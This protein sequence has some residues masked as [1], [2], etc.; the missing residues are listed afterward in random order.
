MFFVLTAPLY[1]Q[2]MEGIEVLEV[3][4]SKKS[5]L[6]NRGFAEG[7]KNGD[8][9]KL[10]LKDLREGVD[11][12]RFVY[13]GEGECINVKNK[14]SYWFLRKIKNF[15]FIKKTQRLVMVRMAKDPR[16]PFVTKRTLRVQG[17]LEDQD[18]Y[19]VSEDSGVPEDLIFEEDDFFKG[20]EVKG[21]TPKKRQD[22][23][24]YRKSPYVS[25]GEEYDE[26]FD[27]VSKNLAA[28]YD[29]GDERL[30]EAI[31][32]EAKN[33][34][35][36]STTKTSV[37]K[38]NDLKYGL[39]GLYKENFTDGSNTRNTMDGLNAYE[40]KI[41]KD[42]LN[43]RVSPSAIARIKREGPMWSK[44]MTDSQLRAYLIDTG[45]EEELQRQ[46]RALKEKEGHEFTLRYTNNLNRNTTSE[47]PNFQ[48][49][50]YAISLSY[51]W[52]LQGTSPFLKNFTFE[53]EAERGISFFDVG[54]INARIQEGSLKGYVNW[55]FLRP[56]FSLHSYMPYVGFGY[57]RGNGTL[58]SAEFDN[59]YD[60]QF[61]SLPSAHFGLKYRFLA[62]DEK[63]SQ[64]NIG[65]GINF[66]VK[67]EAVEYSIT[68]IVVDNINPVFSGSQLRF[69][70]GF[71]VYL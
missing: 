16:R 47:D 56:P 5:I 42:R 22:I 67:Y 36:D 57:K 43:R 9:A 51:E 69:S 25:L 10:Y 65:Y 62:G 31:E 68:D 21:T 14:E 15:R 37:G 55:Y 46:K 19:Q 12:P 63:S 1:A 34:V 17:R 4:S 33:K 35:F 59:V 3:S 61:V 48:N 41:L 52:H 58:E 29:S 44:D 8:R 23:E 27:Q 45:I 2:S 28:P 6:L 53:F 11:S 50:D 60:L 32:A 20:D 66:Q 26:E 39:K 54:G 49:R 38:F 71:N 7:V 24:M 70:I 13:V 40:R 64:L 30:I 18:Y